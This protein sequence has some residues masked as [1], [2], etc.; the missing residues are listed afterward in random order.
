MSKYIYIINAYLWK[1]NQATTLLNK[2]QLPKIENLKIYAKLQ[3]ILTI[4]FEC[5][6]QNLSIW[7]A[8]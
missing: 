2:L 1:Q 8:L 3:N 6:K 5:Y 7:T 4:I